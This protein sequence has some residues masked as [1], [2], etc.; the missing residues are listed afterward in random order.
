[1]ELPAT[2]LLGNF[3]LLQ[4]FYSSRIVLYCV[5]LYNKVFHDT[6]LKQAQGITQH[7]R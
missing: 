2:K 5:A 4:L 7:S 1:M 3:V 6:N